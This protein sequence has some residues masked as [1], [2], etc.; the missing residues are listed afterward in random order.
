MNPLWRRVIEA[1]QA[2]VPLGPRREVPVELGPMTEERALESAIEGLRDGQVHPTHPRYFGL[3]NPAPTELSVMADTLVAAFNPQLATHSHAQ[4]AVDVEAHLIRSFGAKFGFAECEGT[5]TSG[6]AEANTTALLVALNEKYPSVQTTGVRGIAP[7]IYVSAEA[8]PTVA[9]AARIAGLGSDAVR[10]IPA[11][12]KLRMKTRALAETIARDPEPLMIVATAGTTSAGTID[13][14]EEIASIAARSG[15]WLHVDAAWGGFAALIPESKILAGIERADSITFDAHKAL[16]VPMGAGMFMTRKLGALGRTF[17]D[18]A[19][20]MPRDASL[21]PYAHSMMWSRRFIGLKVYLSLA[22]LGFDGYAEKF[23]KQLALGEELRA[24]LRDDGWTIVNDTP[25]PV[26]CFRGDRGDLGAIA[27]AVCN[28][29]WISVTKLSTGERAL[30]ACVIND[31]T[32]SSDIDVL[33][34]ALR[35]AR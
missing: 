19:G 10:V 15:C 16:S 4:W 25:L 7:T 1:M 23:R 3:F 22:V 14:L 13:P 31:R 24:R 9:R 17:A 29:A 2:E 35:R 11:D 5:F 32:T 34:A 33:V 8:H 20:Y 21:D 27:R 30:R 28:E 18:H 6:G 26:V 12:A